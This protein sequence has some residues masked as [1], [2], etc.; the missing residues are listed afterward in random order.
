MRT[1]EVNGLEWKHI[2]FDQDLILVRQ[3]IVKGKLENTKTAPSGFPGIFSEGSY[4]VE[5]TD[6]NRC[7]V[8]VAVPFLTSS[9]PSPLQST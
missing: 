1:G 8:C 9:L 3:T 7:Y 5:F 2:D 4:T 6:P